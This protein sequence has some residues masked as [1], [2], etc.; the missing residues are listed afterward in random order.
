MDSSI[1]FAR[2]RQCA[3]PRGHIGADWRMLLNLC[4]LRPIRV[5]NS[6]GKS[7]SFCTAHGRKSLYFTRGKPFPKTAPSHGGIWTPSN[8]WSLGP[9]WDHNPNRM[10]IDSTVSTQVTAECPYTL[11]WAPFPPKLPLPKGHLDLHLTHDSVGPSEPMTQTGSRSVRPFSH[12]WP[13]S[14][15]I[16]YN[17]TS[18]PPCS[19]LPF[20]MEDMDPHL[21]HGSL[22]QPESSTQTESR[23]VQPFLQGSLVWQTDR[24]TMLL[25]R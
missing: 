7:I 15:P 14:V 2:W 8:S 21:I 23:L 18:L 4:F 13:Q 16:L 9:Y 11:L 3:F 5:H 24:Q 6:N 20:P 25:D 19:K 12:R 10:T 22:G 17:G 1:V